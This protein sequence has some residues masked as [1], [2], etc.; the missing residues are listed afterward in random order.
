MQ[1]SGRTL[2]AW[3]LLLCL[4]VAAELFA[5]HKPTRDER[6]TLRKVKR[7]LAKHDSTKQEKR[8]NAIILPAVYYTP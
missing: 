4:F 2:A 7:E 1:L 3:A 8:L 5:Q 6:I